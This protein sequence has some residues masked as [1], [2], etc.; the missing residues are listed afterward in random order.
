MVVLPPRQDCPD[1][2]DHQHQSDERA[3]TGCGRAPAELIRAVFE[4]IRRRALDLAVA[5][6]GAVLVLRLTVEGDES[7][8]F[9]IVFS[10]DGHVSLTDGPARSGDVD[11]HVTM[12]GSGSELLRLFLGE[13]DVLPA[14]LARTLEF[15]TE[16]KDLV[17]YPRVMRIVRDELW[18]AIESE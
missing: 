6:E 16:P 4:R 18:G 1:K 15:T 7:D 8:R 11:P 14:V 13:T 3:C 5:L 12:R 17:H 10:P 9:T 2:A